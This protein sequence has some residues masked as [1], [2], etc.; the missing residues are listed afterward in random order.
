[1]KK[2]FVPLYCAAICSALMSCSTTKNAAEDS[3]L[4]DST[5][6]TVLSTAKKNS[7][8]DPYSDKKINGE[9]TFAQQLFRSENYKKVDASTLYLQ[10]LLGNTKLTDINLIYKPNTDLAGYL[11]R[12]DTSIYAVYMA[13]EDR[14]KCINAINQY[15]SDYE[16]KKLSS[17]EKKTDQIYGQ[18][19]A[20]E[21]F[22][23][24]ESTMFNFS[25]PTVY[26][27]YKFLDGSPFFIIKFRRSPN[28]AEELGE[29]R[30]P[31]SVDQYY[32]FTRKQAKHLAEFISDDNV[33]TMQE[34]YNSQADAAESEKETYTEAADSS[35]KEL[36]S[37][38]E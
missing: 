29:N 10:A 17:K 5:G 1:M 20:F 18:S 14:R 24:V 32:Y 28:L 34:T 21:E 36:D 15:M 16:N 4:I 13:Q 12:F 11:V 38:K 2:V 30:A 9:K 35:Y 7:V 3:T 8:E 27:G 31:E 25:K 26:Y 6:T 37:G 23:V 33:K 19:G 22:G